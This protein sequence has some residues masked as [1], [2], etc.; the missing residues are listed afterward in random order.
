MAKTLSQVVQT[1]ESGGCLNPLA[2]LR[3]E[4]GAY[5][6]LFAQGNGDRRPGT[7]AT[8]AA[9]QRAHGGPGA[10]SGPSAEMI[11]C[12]SWGS[13]QVMGF[14]LWG[15][16]CNYRLPYSAFID[17]ERDQLNAFADFCG[18]LGINPGAFDLFD[19]DA[20]MKFARIY[21]GP[22]DVPAYVAKMVAARDAS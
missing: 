11:H 12:T 15:P 13:F 1:V 6:N 18:A 20:L 5:D 16:V 14:N 10:L 21:N 22:D 17:S 8:L 3:F 2:A 7:I 9:I 19:P 4:P